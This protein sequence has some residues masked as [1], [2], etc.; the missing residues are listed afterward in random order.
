M[1]SVKWINLPSHW[2]FH[3][4]GYYFI[5]AIKSSF[6]SW[7][8]FENRLPKIFQHL[9]LFIII[10]VNYLQIQVRATYDHRSFENSMIL[11]FSSVS[12][13]LMMEWI[14]EYYEILWLNCT[15]IHIIS[16]IVDTLSKKNIQTDTSNLLYQ[17]MLHCAFWKCMCFT[18][19]KRL[20]CVILPLMKSF[21]SQVY[22]L[23]GVIFIVTYSFNSAL[24]MDFVFFLRL[25]LHS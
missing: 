7:Y 9:F 20:I 12:I 24:L 8:M 14:N 19:N 18:W 16:C 21:Y 4:Q 11:S 17:S 15:C 10:F 25:C 23:T 5:P 1:L 6:L 22:W 3:F 2:T 13:I